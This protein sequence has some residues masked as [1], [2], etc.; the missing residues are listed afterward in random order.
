M[1]LLGKRTL[2]VIFAQ[3]KEQR[4]WNPRSP[5]NMSPGGVNI[6]WTGPCC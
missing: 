6:A 3:G 4:F 5:V 1:D 2:C